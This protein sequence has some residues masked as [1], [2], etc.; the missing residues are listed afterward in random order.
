MV[1]SY[2]DNA[3]QRNPGFKVVA[4]PKSA[5]ICS[6]HKPSHTD[7]IWSIATQPS[8]SVV[9]G[10]K[11][12]VPPAV[13]IQVPITTNANPNELAGSFFVAVLPAVAMIAGGSGQEDVNGEGSGQKELWTQAGSLLK[14]FYCEVSPCLLLHQI[15][16]SAVIAVETWISR[17][18]A[19]LTSKFYYD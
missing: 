15:H 11:F 18:G 12:P 5:G 1:L 3:W 2:Q 6:R 19:M 14:N 17:E 9:V 16:L 13:Q 4:S 7:M 10:T 8:Q